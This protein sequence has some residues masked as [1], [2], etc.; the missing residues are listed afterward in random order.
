M[1]IDSLQIMSNR[2]NCT[3][4]PVGS[5]AFVVVLGCN[6]YSLTM[7]MYS[8]DRFS[9]FDLWLSQ[10]QLRSIHESIIQSK[11]AYTTA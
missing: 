1:R 9:I 4:L 6:V 8:I 10:S 2:R 3:D 5:L 11:S 7:S